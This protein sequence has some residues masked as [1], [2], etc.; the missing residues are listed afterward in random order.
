M[1]KTLLI[2]AIL[3]EP[4]LLILDSPLDGLDRATQQEMRQV[5]DELLH[6]AITVVM[7]CR[8]LEDIPEGISHVMVL[9]EGE[10]SPAAPAAACSIAGSDRTDEP[11]AAGAGRAAPAGAARLPAAGAGPLLALHDVSVSYGELQVLRDVNWVFERGAHC[12]CLGTQRLR[13]DHPAQPD[14]RRQPQGLRPGHYPVRDTPRQWRKCLGYQ[15]EIRPAGHAVA[16]QF[17]QGHDVV[18]VVV[19]GFFDTIGLFDDW[20]DSQREIADQWLAALGLAH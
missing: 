20:G 6:S 17:C 14:H 19:S 7:L 5:I 15:T 11:A 1:R 18:E 8:A 10:V 4:A 3:S 16:P 12:L 9:D 2:K 13:Q